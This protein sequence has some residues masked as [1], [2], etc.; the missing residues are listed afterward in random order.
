M[1][2]LAYGSRGASQNS[3][4]PTGLL[5]NDGSYGGAWSTGKEKNITFKARSRQKQ[6]DSSRAPVTTLIG[7]LCYGKT[8]SRT[9]AA[10]T[11]CNS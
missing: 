8:S 11:E 10:P 5:S 6:V 4:G 9:K 2:I 3:G 1:N 7:E